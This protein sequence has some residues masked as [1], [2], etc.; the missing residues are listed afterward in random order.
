MTLYRAVRAVADSG[1]DGPI[2]WDAAAEVAKASVDPGD[3]TLTAAER[4]GYARDVRAARERVR[5]VA[6]IDFDL[7]ET[8]EV[9]HRHHWIDANVE[10]FRRV[11]KPVA[12]EMREAAFGAGVARTLNTGTM[13]ATLAFLANNVLGQYDP[14]LLAESDDHALYFVHPNIGKVARALDIEE[15]R[16][17]RWIAFHEVAHAA[18]FGAAPWLSDLLEERMQEGVEGLTEGRFD[19]AALKEVNVAMTAVE[20]YAELVMDR[21]FDEEYDDLRR[22]LDARRGGKGPIGKL[23]RRLL[24]LGMKREQYE[25]GKAFFDAVADERGVHGASLVWERP[26]NLPTDEELDHPERWLARGR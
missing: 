4:D 12:E 2:D 23:V 10:T 26:E 15:P 11:M 21:A 17:R 22:K 7:P 20:G 16:F 18:E 13:G 25:R 14:L 9:Q 6:A 19:R 1:G 8:V 24:G 5:E 3:L